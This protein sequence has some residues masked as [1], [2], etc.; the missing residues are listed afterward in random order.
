MIAPSMATAES[1]DQIATTNG[2]ENARTAITMRNVLSRIASSDI[3]SRDQPS[4]V[5][6]PKPK[7]A[8]GSGGEQKVA[9]VGQ[10]RGALVGEVTAPQRVAEHAR[11]KGQ[12]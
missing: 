11:R 7:K 10:C 2:I 8:K 12:D 4:A 9:G 6:R 3:S 1:G 5:R